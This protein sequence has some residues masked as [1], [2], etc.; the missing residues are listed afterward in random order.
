[1]IIYARCNA[2]HACCGDNFFIM[3]DRPIINDENPV[4][5]FVI[6]VINE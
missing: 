3:H 6:V 1:M 2:G 4:H 5:V